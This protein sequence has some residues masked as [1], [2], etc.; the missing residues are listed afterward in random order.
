M[1]NLILASGEFSTSESITFGSIVFP[2]DLFP[3]KAYCRKYI[4]KSYRF[5]LSA[6]LRVILDCADQIHLDVAVAIK[7][8]FGAVL[9]SDNFTIYNPLISGVYQQVLTIP[10]GSLF[11][12]NGT[13]LDMVLTRDQSVYIDDISTD[14]IKISAVE[15]V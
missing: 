4:P 10:V 7:N 12:P 1:A 13:I 5:K 11:H 6:N 15:F 2:S 3:H 9:N 14:S 8:S